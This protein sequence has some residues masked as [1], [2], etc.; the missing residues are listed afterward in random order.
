MR[1]IILIL[2]ITF[3]QCSQKSYDIRSSSYTSLHTMKED[4]IAGSI[5]ERLAQLLRT[6]SGVMVIQS[7]STYSIRIRGV[8]SLNAPT[9]PLYVID[10]IS[11]GHDFNVAASSMAGSHIKSVNVLKGKDASFYGTRGSGGVIVI[12][13]KK[14][15]LAYNR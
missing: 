15:R 13:T 6:K 12:K 14:P 5:E 9:Q 7:G 10:G 2:A 11:L 1:I 3:I 4:N 8:N